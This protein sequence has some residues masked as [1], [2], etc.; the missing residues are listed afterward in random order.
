MAEMKIG[1]LIALLIGI[2]LFGDPDVH[3]E[4]R[5]DSLSDGA[6]YVG[7]LVARST[8]RGF[9]LLAREDGGL[10]EVG[11]L[12]RVGGGKFAFE[13]GE[14]NPAMHFGLPDLIVDLDELDLDEAEEAT[15]RARDGDK[16]LEFRM[17]RS[18]NVVY[19]RKVGSNEM[20]CVHSPESPSP[21]ASAGDE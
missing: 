20:W 21:A 10:V 8:E 18:G 3:K 12:I 19:I 9:S 5:I 17:N 1:A 11:P 15:F 14:Q 7:T 4:I 6:G 13:P 16:A 2:H